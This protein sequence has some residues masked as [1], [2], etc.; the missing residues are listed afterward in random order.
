MTKDSVDR[1]TKHVPLKY[2][3]RT[4][5][6]AYLAYVQPLDNTLLCSPT[7]RHPSWLRHPSP[8]QRKLNSAINKI[9]SSVTANQNENAAAQTSPPVVIACCSL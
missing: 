1:V 2:K 3:V 9:Q 8:P 6:L 7:P 5:S 4:I